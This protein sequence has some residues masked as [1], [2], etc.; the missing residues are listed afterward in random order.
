MGNHVRLFGTTKDIEMQF[1][2]Y[3]NTLS[4]GAIAFEAGVK[5]Y[6]ESGADSSDFE[7]KRNC[8]GTPQKNRLTA[9]VQMGFKAS[10]ESAIRCLY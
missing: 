9:D 5:A 10:H 1:D 4:D 3:L 8:P 2:T 7:T 6:L